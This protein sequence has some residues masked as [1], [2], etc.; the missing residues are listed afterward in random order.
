MI[1]LENVKASYGNDT[2][3]EN[4]SLIINE[5]DFYGIVGPSGVGKSTLLRI[6][7]G[8]LEP[9]EGIVKIDNQKLFANTKIS[10]EEKKKATKDIGYI[11]QDFALFENLSVW[12]NM[13]IVQKEKDNEQI[14]NLLNQF[15]IYD[16][17]YAY[18][19]N[20]SGGQKQ[21]LAIAR[22]LILNPKI[23]LIDEA[24]SSLDNELAYEF[25][26]YMKELNDEGITIVMIS[27]EIEL[28]EKYC[29][30]IYK[31]SDEKTC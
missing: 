17:K 28:V 29:K 8:L 13:A 20:L 22:S 12:D 10:K 3:F 19:D 14:V 9:K 25:M 23:L 4:I 26:D 30:E 18:P 31:I 27:H 24:T 6:I 2:V 15:K 21:R 5:G 7:A 16:R 1:T 11:F